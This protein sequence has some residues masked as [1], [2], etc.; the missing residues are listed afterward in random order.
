M[1]K[2]KEEER[3]KKKLLVTSERAINDISNRFLWSLDKRKIK[4]NV[5][6]PI[7]PVVIL[8]H[9]TLKETAYTRFYFLLK[10]LYIHLA[11]SILY[12]LKFIWKFYN[13]PDIFF[14]FPNFCF[15]I[16]DYIFC[17]FVC[18]MY[19]IYGGKNVFRQMYLF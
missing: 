4:C 1:E 10:K 15:C 12:F 13:Y 14:L 18:Q 16:I 5:S 7:H 17:L 11:G 6:Y 3:K 8:W 9:N 19:H 2:E